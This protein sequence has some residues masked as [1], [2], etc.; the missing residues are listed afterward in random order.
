MSKKLIVEITYNLDEPTKSVIR[1]NAKKEAVE[2][3]LEGWLE[4]QFGRGADESKTN[5]KDVYKIVI[6]L[7]L[8]ED[9]FRTISSDAGNKGLTAGIVADVFK[10]LDEIQ[11]QALEAG[12]EKAV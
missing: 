4:G 6:G 3:I 1:T 9:I 5:E 10:R 2:G 8:T 11:V 12:A 7:D